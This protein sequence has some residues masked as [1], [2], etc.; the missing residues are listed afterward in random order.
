MSRFLRSPVRFLFML[1]L[2]P[3]IGL[4]GLQSTLLVCG[5]L[6]P[7]TPA[8]GGPTILI[9][10]NGGP[11]SPNQAA[12]PGV[13][14]KT[15]RVAVEITDGLAVTKITQV[16]LNEGAAV[17]EGEY[18][19]PLPPGAAVSNLI[20]YIDGQPVTGQLLDAEKALG[21]YTEIV[22]RQRDPALL[23]YAGRGAV[24]LSVFP[25][26]AG[27]ERKVEIT[28]S[29]LA[30]T[31]NGLTAY[32]YPLRTDYASRAAVQEVSVAVTVRST[33]PIRSA[34][35]PDLRVAVNQIDDNTLRA[36][37][38]AANFRA[39][40][41]FSLFYRAGDAQDGIS[42]DVIT[43]RASADED[44][45]F[46]L[47]ITPP[48]KADAERVI[49]KDVLI[50]L[51]QSGSMAGAKWDQARAAVRYVLKN[52]NPA[53][54][55]NVVVFSSGVRIFAKSLQASSEADSAAEWVNSLEAVGGTD[56]NGGLETA[57]R[58]ADAERNTIV[59]FLTDGLPTE[60]VTEIRQIL[61]NVKAAGRPNLR[62]FAF[63][64]GDDVDTFLL[65]SLVAANGGTVA[66]VR[67]Q[68]D[69]EAKVSALYRKLT[70]PVLTALRLEVDGPMLEDMSPATLPDLFAGEQLVITGRYRGSGA[71]TL[72]LR[73]KI[74]AQE[75]AYTFRNLDFP[76]NAGGQP[77]VARLW[78]ARKIGALLNQIKLNGQT[79]ELVDSVIRLSV[80]YGI[81]TPY[82][83][84][85][86]KE[87]EFATNTGGDVNRTTG[88]P[89]PP[90]APIMQAPP[91]APGAPGD[92]TT[93]KD[94]VDF[95][96]KS[97]ELSGGAGLAPA[98]TQAAVV[99]RAGPERERGAAAGGVLRE[100]GDRTFVYRGG[101][102]VDT[103]Y[104]AEM[105]IKVITFLSDDYFALLTAHPD[106]AEAL[107]L[108]DRILIVIGGQAYQIG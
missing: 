100:V 70:A 96:S 106:I 104:T 55:F 83:S 25:I 58:T 103:A 62:L 36:G 7:V 86:V 15:H 22:R 87:D 35:S 91:G 12:N 44:G 59:L 84:Y 51:D 19:F 40:R 42:A 27:G 23:Q 79:P 41:D 105:T 57:L 31:E 92:N 24:K 33:R 68:E 16:F 17:A 29:H 26:P 76:T 89:M 53:D 101:Q 14:L 63:G 2:L 34:Y 20:L 48:Y 98:P 32:I 93:G 3:L 60:G 13:R 99:G 65:D 75:V 46:T 74:G 5:C 85:L 77:F 64:V 66:Y 30:P 81:V 8:V 28:Y 73:G 71:A 21:I 61:A 78:A 11:D 94:S 10:P 50:V 56:I 67:P 1:S 47:L 54:R 108:G 82:T 39:E 69:I 95:S 97:A 90:P 80:R 9:P 52:L 4:F 102:W 38:E 45:F 37:F 6:P 43:Y 49:P 107:A 72:T 88:T 18:L